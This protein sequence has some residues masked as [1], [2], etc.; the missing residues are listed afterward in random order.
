MQVE[1][2]HEGL[3]KSEALSIERMLIRNDGH[4]LLWNVKDYEPFRAE[5]DV[6]VS[7]QEIESFSGNASDH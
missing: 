4:R 5:Q 7:Q 6:Q 2:L 1:L 3:T